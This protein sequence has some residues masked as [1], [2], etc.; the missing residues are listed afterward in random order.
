M[1]FRIS[2]STAMD[3]WNISGWEAAIGVR[4]KNPKRWFTKSQE[5][6]LVCARRTETAVEVK[7]TLEFDLTPVFIIAGAIWAHTVQCTKGIGWL[8]QLFLELMILL[9]V[10]IQNLLGAFIGLVHEGTLTRSNVPEKTNHSPTSL[11]KNSLA[12]ETF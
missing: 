3:F 6:A 4:G 9:H 12:T 8:A 10:R 2:L 1:S 5:M 11:G 7:G